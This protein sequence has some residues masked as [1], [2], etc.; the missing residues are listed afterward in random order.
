MDS[1]F[2]ED[3]A[4]HFCGSF[5]AAAVL[6]RIFDLHEEWIILWFVWLGGVLIETWQHGTGRDTFSWKDM[7]FNTLGII[8]AWGVMR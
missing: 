3:K 5:T 4:F 6:M 7:I 2:A 8:A 1:F